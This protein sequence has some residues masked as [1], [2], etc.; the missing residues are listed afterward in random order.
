MNEWTRGLSRKFLNFLPELDMTI[1]SF[2][3]FFQIHPKFLHDFSWGSGIAGFGG[4][5][6][7]RSRGSARRQ[8]SAVWAKRTPRMAW[9]FYLIGF[10]RSLLGSGIFFEKSRKFSWNFYIDTG[11]TSNCRP[12][13]YI[14]GLLPP[15]KQA[16]FSYGVQPHGSI[17]PLFFSQNRN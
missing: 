10:D 9:L 13:K 1:N 17:S 4:V 3:H 15:T 8:K 11:H 6:A 14:T 2:Q 16:I 5:R 12:G 7:D